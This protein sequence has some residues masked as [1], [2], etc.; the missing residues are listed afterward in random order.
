M[1]AK[2]AE[3]SEKGL[4]YDVTLKLRFFFIF[5]II[6][7][8]TAPVSIVPLCFSDYLFLFVA[9]FF[10]L[11]GYGLTYSCHHKK[12]YLSTMLQKRNKSIIVPLVIGILLLNLLSLVLFFDFN[13][14][15]VFPSGTF[16]FHWFI[17]QLL[18]L[19]YVYYIA[20][21]YCSST[22]TALIILFP[23]IIISMIVL[24][25]LTDPF[26]SLSLIFY[27]QGTFG[28]YLG[29]LWYYAISKKMTV[30]YRI[31]LVIMVLLVAFFLLYNPFGIHYNGPRWT[32]GIPQ[33]LFQ[34][35]VRGIQYIAFL[36]ILFS[37]QTG[38]VTKNK[39]FPLLCLILSAAYLSVLISLNADLCYQSPAGIM[40]L[41][42]LAITLSG[43]SRTSKALIFLGSFSYE[44][45][46]M[47]QPVFSIFNSFSQNNNISD[48]VLLFFANLIITFVVSYLV[49]R[50]S[51]KTLA[52]LKEKE[53]NN[54]LS[55]SQNS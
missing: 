7:Y 44:L 52:I 8:H 42:F 28:F 54:R 51:S 47:H 18:F 55:N 50:L 20:F 11:S 27:A 32:S 10:F 31:F 29:I 16:P 2:K 33:G 12:N 36:C 22:K 25:I 41:T 48:E 5:F 1:F 17:L 45:F 35:V 21:N 13:K 37:V 38:M 49:Y 4:E 46:I 34:M 15:F 40:V 30:D 26:Y 14:L 19:Y 43:L 9:P 6:L 23:L 3:F 24:C 39:W 53:S